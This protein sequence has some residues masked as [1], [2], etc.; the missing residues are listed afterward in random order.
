MTITVEA[1][2]HQRNGVGGEAFTTAIVRDTTDNPDEGRFLIVFV[3]ER[4][5][6]TGQITGVQT[7]DGA[8][9]FVNSLDAAANGDLTHHWRGD[10]LIKDWLPALA[11]ADL[12][13][14][15][16]RSRETAKIAQQNAERYD[17]EGNTKDAC[18]SRDSVRYFT[19]A[20][21]K[22]EALANTL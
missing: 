11:K 20:A 12:L 16:A 9:S 13:R 15:A 19:E 5:K 10:R 2:D 21:E 1:I 4:D 18:M 17:Q 22:T 6:D 3:P 8:L 7:H 14:D